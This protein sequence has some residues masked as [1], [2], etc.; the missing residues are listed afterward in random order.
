[1]K[2]PYVAKACAPRKLS[3]AAGVRGRRGVGR[4][5]EIGPREA[6]LLRPVVAVA[7][8]DL[9]RGE[10]RA[11]GSGNNRPPGP[12]WY[13]HGASRA[14]SGTG[15]PPSA[16]GPQSSWLSEVVPEKPQLFACSSGVRAR[17]RFISAHASSV[18]ARR[19]QSETADSGGSR[20]WT[21][22]APP[23]ADGALP[24]ARRAQP[25]RH[26]GARGLDLGGAPGGVQPRE[27]AVPV[28][29][30]GH[31]RRAHQ[32]EPLAVDDS[33]SRRTRSSRSGRRGCSPR[34]TSASG[35]SCR[36]RRRA[37]RCSRRSR[38]AG[39]RRS[40]AAPRCGRRRPGGRRGSPRRARTSSRARRGRDVELVVLEREPDEMPLLQRG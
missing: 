28:D 40:S 36:C 33:P 38:R 10:A 34:G 19:L 1:M 3:T 39:A 32:I 2:G 4:A 16:A 14:S 22:G 27:A 9:R 13:V 24:R 6:R 7:A 25:A 20:G 30:L 21:P 5:P 29:D 11:R 26:L 35:P 23:G 12:R 8:G 17:M 37:G 31:A 18:R 15:S